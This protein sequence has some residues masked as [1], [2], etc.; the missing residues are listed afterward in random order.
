MRWRLYLFGGMKNA[1]LVTVSGATEVV[2]TMTISG[3]QDP[4]AS[5]CAT[6]NVD[7]LRASL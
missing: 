4:A 5:N 2:V 6:G 7:A 1:A 3:T